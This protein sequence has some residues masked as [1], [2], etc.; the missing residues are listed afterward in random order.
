MLKFV[1]ASIGDTIAKRKANRRTTGKSNITRENYFQ[2]QSYHSP[3]AEEKLACMQ[4]AIYWPLIL[5]S[6]PRFHF[7]NTADVAARE[8][9]HCRTFFDCQEHGA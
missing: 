4:N 6:T 7:F 5:S 9:R 8:A 2:G 3:G 1:S